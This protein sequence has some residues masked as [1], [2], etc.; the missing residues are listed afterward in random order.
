[1]D[2]NV[3]AYAYDE[4]DPEKHGRARSLLN[5]LWV[6]RAAVVSTQVLSELYSVM[7]RKLGYLPAEAR[8][9]VL[10][11]TAWRVVAVDVPLLAAA[12]ERNERDVIAW[13]DALVV[14]AALRAGAIRLATEDL[15]HGRIF[16]GTLQ[17]WDPL[18]S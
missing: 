17:V 5:R 2:T 4:T 9:I 11:Y 7:T 18:A 15:Q 1:V 10:Q 3:L 6:D 12:M 14:E 13:W 16:D 8:E